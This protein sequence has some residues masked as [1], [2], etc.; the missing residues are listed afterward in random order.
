MEDNFDD[1]MSTKSGYSSVSITKSSNH[2]MISYQH[3][4]SSVNAIIKK[5][6]SKN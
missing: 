1:G 3:D 2:S 4:V 5:I 6:K